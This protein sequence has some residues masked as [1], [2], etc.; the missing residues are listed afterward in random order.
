M[1][2]S[3]VFALAAIVGLAPFAVDMYLSS[4][5]A[6]SQEF[7]AP[8]WVNQLTLTGYLLVL[9]V[10][11]LV[12]GPITDSVGRRGPL[13][14]GLTLFVMGALLAAVAPTIEVLVAA[15]LLQ[16]LGGAIAVVVANSSVRDRARGEEATRLYAVL[17]TVMALAPV[18]A[19]A[20]GGVV[21]LHFGWRTVFI[22]L[23]VLGV[24]VLLCALFLLPE[25]LPVAKRVPFA[26]ADVMAGYVELGRTRAFLA[27]L[28]ALS[29]VFMV[30]FAYI[31]GASYVYQ[32]VYGLNAA[33][34]GMVFGATGLAL[35]IGAF[36]ASRQPLGLASA[37]LA[38]AGI[39][40]MVA[41]GALAFA[42]IK[43]TLS[44]WVVVVGMALILFGLGACEPALMSMCMSAVGEG[45]GS[46]AAVIGA[47]QH[48]LGAAASAIA[49][50]V[51][52]ATPAGWAVILF[53]CA[54]VAL[55]FAILANK[56]GQE[57]RLPSA[58]APEAAS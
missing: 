53:T 29:A 42:A 47:A 28:A 33:V 3:A 32:N 7:A 58:A 36:V 4:L 23:A 5:P 21:E 12:A 44:L 9:G 8:V 48:V 24:L 56:A 54:V 31:G 39:I 46:A 51:A 14:A 13:I 1:R 55:T 52:A 50:V 27:P 11:Q 57:G 26:V 17:L 41:G 19:P 22:V 6:I 37:T 10:G 35:I 15:R 16:G 30:L 38:W 43:L 20:V 18:I 49:G 25:S 34:F 40:A 45:T 2:R